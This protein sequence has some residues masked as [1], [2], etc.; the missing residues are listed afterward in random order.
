MTH[1]QSDTNQTNLE[2]FRIL[3][4][5]GGGGSGPDHW[6]TFWEHQ[7]DHMEWVGPFDWNNGTRKH[8]VDALDQHIALSERPTLLVAH[9]L[10]NMAVC[11][12]AAKR[13]GPVVGALLVAPADVDA[14][15]ADSGAMYQDFGPVPMETLPFPSILVTSS[16]DPYI[17]EDRAR[18]F[19]TAWGARL[20][21]AG[22]LG[23]I[24]S[25]SRLEHWKDG[26]GF[27]R[28]VAQQK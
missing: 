14:P 1:N 20:R 24:G 12:W 26:L 7:H 4:V 22:A 17:T 10:G 8:W 2:N 21:L 25:D 19:A 27:L 9:S 16:D 11:H 18:A 5:P 23:H 3:L 28:Q 13:S 15:W 6:Q